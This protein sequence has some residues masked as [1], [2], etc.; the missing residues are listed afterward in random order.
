MWRDLNPYAVAIARFR[1]LIA[2][3][4]ACGI[5][6]LSE[7]HNWHFNVIV[8]DSLLFGAKAML[9]PDMLSTHLKT[10]RPFGHVCRSNDITPWSAI[11]R[12]LTCKIR[13]LRGKYRELVHIVLSEA[14]RL[15]LPLRSCSFATRYG[16]VGLITSNGFMK[17][18][19]RSAIRQEMS[20]AAGT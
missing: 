10:R 5:S 8:A 6:R 12:T 20:A 18:S 15:A 11:R 16:Y 1:L 9:N 17:R 4:K 14:I 3:V 7:A 13:S 19:I 2:A